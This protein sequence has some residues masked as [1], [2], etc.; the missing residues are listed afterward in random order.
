MSHLAFMQLPIAEAAKFDLP[1]TRMVDKGNDTL[2]RAT[3][4]TELYESLKRRKGI[5]IKEL[6]DADMNSATGRYALEFGYVY[7][8]P[9]ADGSVDLYMMKKD[10]SKVAGVTPSESKGQQRGG[11]S[12]PLSYTVEV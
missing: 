4:G 1:F 7:A 10:L 6:S 3:V 9:S 11:S 2:Y 12:L 5:T 8:Q